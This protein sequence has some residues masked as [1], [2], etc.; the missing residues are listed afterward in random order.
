MVG[1]WQRREEK[2]VWVRTA[3]HGEEL[4]FSLMKDWPLTIVLVM[5]V[6][7]ART[8]PAPR[9]SFRFIFSAFSPSGC[10]SEDSTIFQ[11][12]LK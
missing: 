11:T 6:V 10:C 4:G 5:L 8:P 7:P 3:G 2:R 1:A 9:H 12:R